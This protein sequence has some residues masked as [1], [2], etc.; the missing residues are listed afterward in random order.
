MNKLDLYPLRDEKNILKN[1]HKGWYWHFIDCGYSRPR[2]RDNAELIGDAD[3]FPGLTQLYLRFDWT[4]INPKKGVYDFSYLDEIMNS[5]G[6]RG[7]SFSMRMTTFQ[8]ETHRWGNNQRATPNYVRESGAKGFEYT[9]IDAEDPSIQYADKAWEPDYAD[10]IYLGYLEETL[11][12]LGEKYNKDNRVEYVDVG[13]FGR[14][15]EGHTTQPKKYTEAELRRHI[16]LTR[17]A[18]PDKLILINDDMLRYNQCIMRESLTEYCL[19]KGI[20]IRDDSICVAGPSREGFTY[21]TL[22]DPKLF[23]SFCDRYPVDIEFAHAEL[24]PVD[25]WR[26]GFP[27]MESLKRTKATFAGFHDYPGRFMEQNGN[28]AEYAA[29]RLGYWYRPDSIE[30]TSDG[31]TFTVSNLGWAPSYRDYSL[32]LFLQSENGQIMDMGH[33]AGSA[34]WKEQSSS[35]CSFRF[36]NPIPAGKYTV[37]IGMYDTDGTPIQL[38]LRK[39]CR[40]GEKYELGTVDIE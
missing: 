18:F 7:Y 23:D 19:S 39:E 25:V 15:G 32:K 2:Y 13:S 3:A 30:L 21:D 26:G 6:E 5:W 4:D 38:A 31:G 16:D 1:P 36:A 33:I 10:D 34:A 22:R 24:I 9:I 37:L 12:R 35:T 17:A 29:N 40:K 27:A 28:L 14:Y 20:G 11:M 8:T